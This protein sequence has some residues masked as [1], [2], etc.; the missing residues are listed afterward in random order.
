MVDD[1]LER[2]IEAI[3]S[4]AA[5]KPFMIRVWIFG[6]RARGDH[7][8]DSDLDIAIEHEALPGDNN[9]IVTGFDQK[10]WQDELQERTTLPVHVHSYIPGVYTRIGAALERSSRL[11]YLR[12]AR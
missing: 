11:I 7:R 10:L 1:V 8:P 4:W 3:R 2:D 5:E 12:A 9:A 6:S